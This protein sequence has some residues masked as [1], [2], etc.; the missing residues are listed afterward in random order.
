MELKLGRAV[1]LNY[2]KFSA[3]MLMSD[4]GLEDIDKIKVHKM[5]YS[6]LIGGMDFLLVKGADLRV[7]AITIQSQPGPRNSQRLAAL[8][9]NDPEQQDDRHAEP[10][11]QGDDHEMDFL[12]EIDGL[13]EYPRQSL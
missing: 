8:P 2:D 11:S 5:N 9:D 10:A 12:D 13:Y 3:K 6:V 1:S 4:P 7:S